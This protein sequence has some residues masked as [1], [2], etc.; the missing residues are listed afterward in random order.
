MLHKHLGDAAFIRGAQ[1]RAQEH[2]PEGQQ[3]HPEE[4]GHDVTALEGGDGEKESDGDETN[5]E[6]AL[7]FLTLDAN[8]FFL[9]LDDAVASASGN[10]AHAGLVLVFL[11]RIDQNVLE[12]IAGQEFGHGPGEHGLARTRIPDHQHVTALFSGLPDDDR[13]GFLADDLIDQTVRN[14]DFFGRRHAD[15]VDPCLNAALKHVVAGLAK[16]SLVGRIIRFRGPHRH[17]DVIL[18]GRHGLD[19]TVR[20]VFGR[21]RNLVGVS[22]HGRTCVRLPFEA[23]SGGVNDVASAPHCWR[24]RYCWP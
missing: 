24:S 13:A 11:V 21:T 15:V 2:V 10:R 4:E 1:A 18:D 17:L 12:G 19:E 7:G 6:H 5:E 8:G 20:L 9:N 14:R 23:F 3:E 22:A 16:D